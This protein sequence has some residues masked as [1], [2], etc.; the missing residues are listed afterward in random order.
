MPASK[1]LIVDDHESFRQFLCRAL[2]EHTEYQVIGEATDGLGAVQ[3][4]EELQPDLYLLDLGLPKLN[5]MEVLRRVRKLSYTFQDFD[6]PSRLL[7]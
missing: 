6:Y 4:A 5:G 2:E 1:A 7:G 3:K